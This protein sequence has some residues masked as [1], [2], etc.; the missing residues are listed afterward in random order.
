MVLTISEIFDKEPG[1]GI[2][3]APYEAEALIDFTGPPGSMTGVYYG[4]MFQ[5]GK[6]GFQT[7]KIDEWI[8]VSPVFKQYYDLTLQQK[9]ALEVQIKAGLGQI[10]TAIH[11]YE[12]VFHDLRKY[13]EFLDHFSFIEEGKKLIKEGKKEE[14]GKKQK[15]GEQTLKAIFIDEVDIHTD[16]PNTP[17]AL[18]SIVGRW[19]TVIADFMRLSDADTDPE[20]IAKKL[21]VS[22]AEGV[23]LATK[24]K[25]Y[26]EWRDRLFRPTVEERYERILRLV[27]SRKFSI[28]EYTRMLKPVVARFKMMTDALET[29]EGRAGARASFFRPDAQ[30][31][32]IDFMRLWAWKPFS[33]S[34]KYKITR[35][36]LDEISPRKAGFTKEEVERLTEVFNSKKEKGLTYDEKKFLDDKKVLA[37]PVEPSVGYKDDDIVRQYFDSKD[38]KPSKIEREYEVKIDVVDLFDARS[39]LTESY[40]RRAA[41]AWSPETGAYKA[42]A[43]GRWAV[44]G[45][46][47]VFSPYFVFIDL[48]LLR[49]MLKIPDGSELEDLWIENLRTVNKTQNVI[50]VHLLEVIAREKQLENYISQL[51]G[52]VGGKDLKDFRSLKSIEE[53]KKEQYPQ[54]FGELKKIKEKKSTDL[55]KPFKTVKVILGDILRSFGLTTPF[56]DYLR[57]RGPYEFALDDR[58]TEI[59][60]PGPGEL[61]GTVKNYLLQAIGVPGVRW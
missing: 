3:A 21:K 26:L 1:K 44:P 34:E 53:M 18:R 48:P 29:P 23:V 47:W 43:S 7:A 14:G 56:V 9:Q 50:I 10:A 20:N 25:L 27:E 46:G 38:G 61:F 15:E 28:D 58:L 33:P 41:D 31:Y 6:W 5:L 17:I 11:D 37:L 49:T 24:N 51:V 13:K 57:A 39:R 12:L 8:N 35:E 4:L 59:Y 54:I 22:E 36:F 16:L 45:E 52:E 2:N 42:T 19:P 40:R 32:S 30:A 60:Q 55:T